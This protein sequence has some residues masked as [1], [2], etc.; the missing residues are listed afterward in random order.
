MLH[1]NSFLYFIFGQVRIRRATLSKFPTYGDLYQ[2]LSSTTGEIPIA[3]FRT[4][5]QNPASSEM[6]NVRADKAP[7]CNFSVF[8][9]ENDLYLY[10]EKKGRC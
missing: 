2:G 7:L 9:I 1:F 3:I 5:K 10:R 4:E 8:V 6:S